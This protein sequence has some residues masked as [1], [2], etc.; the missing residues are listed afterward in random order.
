MASN[1][2][3]KTKYEPSEDLAE[4]VGAKDISRP[5]VVKKLWIYI[6]K[7]KLQDGRLILASQDDVLGN[8]L[9]HKDVDMLKMSGLLSKHLTRV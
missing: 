5:D 1:A 4:I 9:G 6:K 2:L 3:M 8:V 7:H